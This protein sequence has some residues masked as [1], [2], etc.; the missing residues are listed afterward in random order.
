MNLIEFDF[1]FKTKFSVNPD[2]YPKGWKRKQIIEAEL[3][4]FY[5]DQKS[6][7]ELLIDEDEYEV[8]I[9]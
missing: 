4:A 6:Y 7:L 9:T 8:Q 2:S 3:D 1:V 5:A